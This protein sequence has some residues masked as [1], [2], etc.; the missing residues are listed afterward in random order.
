MSSGNVPF[1]KMN[2]LGNDFAVFD[3]RVH[4]IAFSADMARRVASREHGVGC[5]QVVFLEPSSRADVFMRILNADGSEVAACG[6]ATRC[7]AML[8]ARETGR[9]TVSI[10]TP[11][12]LVTAHAGDDG[13]ISADMGRPRFGWAE[14]PLARQMDTAALDFRVEV[15][16]SPAL[17]RPSA[18]SVG[19]PHCIFW[20][21]SHAPYDLAAI[22]PRVET[23]A[24]FPER[25]NVS[26][27]RVVSPDLIEL[28]VWE[29]G[30][31]L[32][33]ACGT[34]ACATAVAAARIGL[35]S[36][37]VTVQLPGGRLQVEWRAGDDH[38]IMTGP[39][40]LDYAGEFSLTDGAV[41][42]AQGQ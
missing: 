2:G 9:Q 14:I 15:P 5:D 34:A 38:I 18:V 21:A 1:L 28:A 40:E 26:L 30:T 35:A 17:D 8:L 41:T 13:Q 20:V 37:N 12:G 3:A 7:A 33:R 31:G 23:D 4:P 27:A 29:R 36:R 32:T 22:G 10:E 6:N 19:N 39:A 24:L 42:R 16:G 11:A 25:V